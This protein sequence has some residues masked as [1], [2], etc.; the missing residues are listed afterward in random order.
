[1]T[2]TIDLQ[3]DDDFLTLVDPSVLTAAVT[4]ALAMCGQEDGMLS[5]VITDD[6]TVQQL[7][8]DY[9][10]VDAP[11]DVL[12]FANQEAPTDAGSV[13]QISGL[14]PDVAAGLDSYLGDIIIAYPYAERQAADYQNDVTAELRLL[15][16]HGVLHLLGYDH[17]TVEEE[18]EMWA[19]QTKILDHF[20]NA[21]L[22]ERIYRSDP[23][24]A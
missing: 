6:E 16:I 10:G 24:H 20:G 17:G 11:T 9:R 14:P 7:N 8:R 13:Q 1:M 15:A 21:N 12:S 2:T 3:I 23:D 19:V 22:S 4:H 5:L 18:A